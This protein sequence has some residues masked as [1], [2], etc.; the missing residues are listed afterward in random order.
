MKKS[1]LTPVLL[2][3]LLMATNVKAQMG[4]GTATPHSSAQLDVSS[5]LKG[6]LA[7]RMT[8]A[9]RNAVAT[10]AEGLLVY[11][12]DSTPGFYYYNGTA[13][14]A[15]SGSGGGSGVDLT[16]NQSVGGKKTFTSNDGFLATGTSGSGT[17]SSLGAGTRMMWYPKMAA[18][19]AGAVDGTQWDDANIGGASAA[20][21]F[22]TKAS[23][24]ISF[25]IGSST[26]A[27]GG[28]STAMGSQTIA[29]GGNSTAMGGSTTASG[30]VSTA[31]GNSTTASAINSTAMGY[32]TIAS[33]ESATAMGGTSTAS[34]TNSTAMGSQTIASG[35]GATAMG[36]KSTASGK[37][38]TA[39]GNST[40]AQSL[41]ETAIGTYNTTYTPTSATL[42][43]SAD[44]LFVIGNGTSSSALS[45][46]LVMLKNG[47]T[48]IGGSLALNGNGTST[49][50][51][52]PTTRGTANYVL[53]TDGVGGTSW[54]AASG[55]SGV[56]LTTNQSVGGKKTFTS[57][58]G[59][60]ATGTSGSGTAS[61]LGAGPRMMWY[62]KSA[63]FR[64]GE[65]LGTE[66]D[67]A[68]IGLFSV[69]MGLATKASGH[70]STAMGYSTIA[71]ADYSTAMGNS[72]IASAKFSTAMGST[73]R[74]SGEYSTAMGNGTTASNVSSTAMG[75]GSIASQPFS[76]AMGYGTTAS[77]LASSAM[78]VST[79]ASSQA[80]TAMG[81]STTASA[82][83]STAMGNSTTA[84]G[85]ASTAMGYYTTAKSLA[86]TAI[87]TY[88]TNYSPTNGF[89]YNATERLFVIGN[90]TSSSALSDALVMLKNGNTTFSGTVTATV[91]APTSDA[92]LKRNIVP[93]KNSIEAIMKLKPVSYEKKNSLTSTDYNIKEN[94]FIAQ[95]LQ[96]VMPSL[97]V[98][99]TDKDKLLSVNYTA[100]IPM[101]TKAIQEQQKVIQEQQKA[102]QDQHANIKSLEKNAEEQQKQ[103]VELKK[104]VEQLLK[105]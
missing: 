24:D 15:L 32:N 7:P 44:R 9:Q 102:I 53:T 1:I 51:T 91:V 89:Q 39:M 67:D 27:S 66:W 3:V 73:T 85:V 50:Y 74:A 8:F 98:M 86:E 90:G 36:G 38:S 57:N 31:M 21:G 28:F 20:M 65:A 58:D 105:K 97:V 46:A 95:E 52:F 64:V 34:A 2:V 47:N 82:S 84:S 42:Y 96:K 5:V 14:V 35:E 103:I 56:D 18:F 43:N 61:S 79:T 94:G 22:K 25:A 17:A 16:T 80:A 41:A 77:G 83:N 69:A 92:R 12:T 49:S 30:E 70:F 13:W 68:N 62:P 71:S 87:G 23:G 48:T 101:L 40:T 72:T 19:R 81:N 10:P 45:D 54:A 63:A 37:F 11:Q 55:G 93:L 60:L 88:N 29:S 99:G 6:F 26:T 104:M 75:D 76:T 4:I 59:F 100:I 78:G 33:G